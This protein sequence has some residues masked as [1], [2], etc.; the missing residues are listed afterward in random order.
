MDFIKQLCTV[1]A[2][3]IVNAGP[4]H[5]WKRE[6]RRGVWEF[7]SSASGRARPSERV[8]GCVRVVSCARTSIEQERALP[9][10][11]SVRS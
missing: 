3:C 4:P 5:F 10:V 6:E 9:S 2:Y 8:R 11:A 1:H 7:C